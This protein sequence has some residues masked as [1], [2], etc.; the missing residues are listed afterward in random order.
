V[1]NVLVVVGLM[2]AVSGWFLRGRAHDWQPR[3]AK[4]LSD[5]LYLALIAL[6]AA[7]YIARRMLGARTARAESGRRHHLFYWSHVGPAIIAAAAV[8]LGFAYGWL[9]APWLDA[10]IPFWA[11]PFALG[12]LSLPRKRELTDLERTGTDR[13]PVST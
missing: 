3:P 9:V 5:S 8:P 1:L 6:A 4:T 2:I 13:G 10:V 12:C 11:V 7:S